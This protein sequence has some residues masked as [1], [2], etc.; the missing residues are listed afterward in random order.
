LHSYS[1]C[2]EDSDTLAHGRLDVN[3]FHVMPSL[4]QQGSQE[5]EGHNGVLSDLFISHGFVSNGN[6][7]VGNFLKLPL[8][9]SSSV[10]DLLGDIVILGDW[11]WEHTNSVKNWTK[12]KWNLLD[13]GVSSQKNGVLL[14]PLLNQFLIL[15]EFLE[16][17]HV[18][19]IN[20]LQVGG[21]GL[22]GMLLIGDEADFHVWSWDVWEDNGT[23]ETLI[24]LWI[25]ILKGNLEFNSLGESSLLGTLPHSVD[26][27]EHERVGNL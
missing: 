22:I 2:S 27:L 15:V 24:F 20:T 4:L 19:N 13:E 18:N 10:I 21:L 23:C 9:G 6:V 26:A 17:V 7:Q 16:E 14:S 12:G 3:S 1:T 5:V 25:I 11:C 8:D